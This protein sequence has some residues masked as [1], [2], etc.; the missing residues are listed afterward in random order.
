MNAYVHLHQ[1]YWGVPVT[2]LA[3]EDYSGGEFEF[4]RPPE[5]EGVRWQGEEIAT[6]SFSSVLI[7]YL[8][9]IEDKH[10]IIMLADYM[11]T[12][13]VDEKRLLQLE[14][15]MCAHGNILRGQVG[16]DGGYCCGQKTDVY[17]DIS[18]WEG[19]FLP[20][21]LTPGM[22]DRALLLEMMDIGLSA[23]AME[24]KGRDKFFRAGWRSIAPSPGC[25][26][27]L[28]ALRGRSLENIVM[29][30]EVYQEIGQFL[31]IQPK[32]FIKLRKKK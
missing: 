14:E 11:I 6:D 5:G 2:L 24:I 13:P 3:E 29:T 28:N 7:W 1:K 30:E 26:S 20:T 25:M 23:W 12:E 15:Y 16:D 8:R 32:A 9:Q 21:S 10:V 18:I 4:L 27:Y 17:K 19:N 22:W 31:Q